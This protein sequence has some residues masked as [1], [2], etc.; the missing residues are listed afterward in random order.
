MRDSNRSSLELGLSITRSQ[1]E[2]ISWTE[3][4][5]VEKIGV[6]VKGIV[7]P[8]AALGAEHNAMGHRTFFT[9]N[10]L[11]A[12]TLEL[13]GEEFQHMTRVL[14]LGPG[15]EARVTDGRGG[16]AVVRVEAVRRD[17][18]EV[19]VPAVERVP[20]GEPVTV[21]AA[22]PRG[23]RAKWLVEKCTELGAAEI[24]FVTFARSVVNEPGEEK[25]R[26]LR[27]AAVAALK[28]SG[29]CWLPD[30]APPVS[31]DAFLGAGSSKLPVLLD[32][33]TGRTLPEILGPPRPGGILIAA[34]PEGGLTPEEEEA[35]RTAGFVP[36]R[37]SRAVLRVETAVLAALAVIEAAESESEGADHDA[38]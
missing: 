16:C 15:D 7:L 12:G 33:R 26:G 10:P 24:R 19:D 21:A 34:G 29:R 23:R 4:G 22:L 38:N 20:R 9:E 30:L 31:L 14:R 6:S 13:R 1:S 32:P 17:A 3:A 25:I 18:V 11:A 28:Q 2:W 5:I 36:A 8:P 35:M 27:S 37:L